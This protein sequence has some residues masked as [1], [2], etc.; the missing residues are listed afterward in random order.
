MSFSR[1]DYGYVAGLVGLAAFSLAVRILSPSDIFDNDQSGPISHIADVA[2]NGHW[3]MQQT[4]RG[5]LATKPPMYPWL[6]A[7]AVRATG[8]TD[9]LVFKLPV[10][11]AF[12]VV[13]L[14][15]FDWTRRTAG[16][17][18]AAVACAIWIANYHVFKLMYT[19]RTDM[20]I[21]MWVVLAIWSVDR[22]RQT[23]KVHVKSLGNR[24]QVALILM[25][26]A[27]VGAG[28]LTKGPP[29]LIPI[30]WLIS[31]VVYEGAWRRCRPVWQLVGV[32]LSVA[33]LLAWLVPT[34]RAYPQWAQNINAEVIERVTGAGSGAHRH[35]SAFAIPGY[36]LAR[37]APWSVLFV[38]GG[39]LWWGT[40]RDP[41][42][43]LSA[44][45]LGWVALVLVI[46]MIPHGKRADYIVPAYP[47]AAFL[48]AVFVAAAQSRK[49]W[50]RGVVHLT[51]GGVAV[52]GIACA[53]ASPWL[54]QSPE[55]EL[56][57]SFQ[58]IPNSEYLIY[59]CACA[60][61]FAAAP[62]LWLIHRR[63]YNLGAMVCCFVLIAM[64]GIYQS[65]LSRAAKTYRGEVIIALV[66]TARSLG[67]EERLPIHCYGRAAG[68][69]QALLGY[70][71]LDAE[72]AWDALSDGALLLIGDDEWPVQASRFSGRS[73]IVLQTQPI[74]NKKDTILLVRIGDQTKA[75]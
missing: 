5:K 9:E 57:Y 18:I 43:P 31:V 45:P 36:F 49:G 52:S 15:V 11:L 17:A 4:P 12:V 27:T 48:V 34:L 60:A 71:Q 42:Q 68:R 38:A 75:S 73:T 62:V 39:L 35:S 25:F 44:W 24:T 14:V 8:R 40:R 50:H 65:T 63:R 53:V 30:V 72:F 66:K 28:L 67:Q 29:A 22:Q 41:K 69:F 7:L 3:L 47:A 16:G 20:I 13:T 19:A 37:F 74:N 64:L 1:R 32:L 46:F 70:H 61:A 21:T 51:L 6:G 26:G 33:M 59:G 23:W 58:V 56:L 2:F 10:V 54:A 55:S